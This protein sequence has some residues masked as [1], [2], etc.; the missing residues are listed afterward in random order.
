MMLDG[1]DIGFKHRDDRKIEETNFVSLH[2]DNEN[3]Y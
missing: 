3:L 2:T 1:Y